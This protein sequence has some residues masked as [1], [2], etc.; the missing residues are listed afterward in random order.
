[1]DAELAAGVPIAAIPTGLALDGIDEI[2]V[3]FLSYCSHEWRDHM[4]DTLTGADGRPVSVDAGSDRWTVRIT[5]AGADVARD[6]DAGAARVS[7]TPQELLLW[8]WRRSDR[9]AITTDGDEKLVA[10]LWDLLGATTV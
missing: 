5:P 10:R 2:L 7:G 9:A 1:M 4:A 6:D 3:R 8:L